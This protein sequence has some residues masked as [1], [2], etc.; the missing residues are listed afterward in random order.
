MRKAASSESTAQ[1][2][3]L[4]DMVVE[5]VSLVDRAAN[6]RKFLVVKRDGEEGTMGIGAPVMQQANG[7][8][9]AGA[10]PAGQTALASGVVP[11]GDE[12]TK[13]SI[14]L[15]K[16]EQSM[17]TDSIESAIDTLNDALDMVKK[18]KVVDPTD[19]EASDADALLESVMGAAE[20]LSDTCSAFMNAPEPTSE[21]DEE[22]D[23]D[24]GSP[25]AAGAAPAAVA[26]SA[27]SPPPAPSLPLGKRL[28]VRRAKRVIAKSEGEL[29]GKTMIA[30]Y[31]MKMSKER[32]QRFQTAM[33]VLSD[34]FGEVQPMLRD[35]AKK[36][37]PGDKGAA[38][39]PMP[40]V[41]P[42]KASAKKAAEDAEL[43]AKNADLAKQLSEV[44]AVAKRQAVELSKRA[45][46]R[47]TSNAAVV[48]P[49]SVRKSQEDDV[50]WPQDLNDDRYNRETAGKDFFG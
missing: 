19:G 49:T 13:A 44:Q 1:I 42:G 39:N 35:K 18:A 20:D 25:P 6:R 22:G 46:E 31:G 16:D 8:F 15:S 23:L 27:G 26:A 3:R 30:K 10:L 9:V 43:A 45:G 47:G 12:V 33:K 32:V 50:S 34:I 28:E 4:H 40:P 29:F 7:S 17:F 5:E 37:K 38:G 24:G 21:D 41:P 48:E 11:T 36:P 14:S 2:Y